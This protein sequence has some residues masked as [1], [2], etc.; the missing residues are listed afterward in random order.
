MNNG[1]PKNFK[2]LFIDLNDRNSDNIITDQLT[3]LRKSGHQKV[4][5]EAKN[6]TGAETIN[7]QVE[8][9][10]ISRIKEIQDLPDWVIIKLILADKKLRNNRFKERLSDG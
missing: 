3:E 10:L 6:K 8:I 9:D 5:L 4:N 2:S 1:E 7:L